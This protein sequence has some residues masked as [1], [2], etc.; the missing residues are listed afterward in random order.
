MSVCV[1]LIECLNTTLSSQSLSDP[2]TIAFMLHK[3]DLITRQVLTD[4]E[5]TSYCIS[6]IFRGVKF[7]RIGQK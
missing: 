6:G 2:V 5:S 3:E 1:F 4:I 7:S